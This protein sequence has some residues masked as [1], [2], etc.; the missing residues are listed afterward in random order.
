MLALRHDLAFIQHQD[1]V[2]VDHGADALR[3]DEG[4]AAFHQR[5]ERFLDLRLGRQIHAG[6]RVVQD[7][8]ARIEQ[9]GAGD[10]D[11][12]L[13]SAAE[14]GAAFADGRVVAIGEGHDEVM[15]GGGFGGG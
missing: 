4:R 12:L 5:V 2:G 13:L 15:R 1:L 9:Q 8:D 14:G 3:D 6:G 10:G 7:Q 11:A